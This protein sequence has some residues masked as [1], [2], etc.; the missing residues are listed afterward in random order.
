MNNKQQAEDAFLKDSL[1]SDMRL[2]TIK[3]A[4]AAGFKRGVESR[5]EALAV[6]FEHGRLEG[7]AIIP[8]ACFCSCGS[9]T[10]ITT[11]V[12]CYDV[13]DNCRKYIRE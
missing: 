1:M 6:A 11:V 2:K 8:C 4:H 7:T 5:D 12:G 13:C 9:R 10:V 3:K